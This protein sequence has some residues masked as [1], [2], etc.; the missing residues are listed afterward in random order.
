MCEMKKF[1]PNGYIIAL[2]K[3]TKTVLYHECTDAM[4]KENYKDLKSTC[5]LL[6]LIHTEGQ[7]NSSPLFEA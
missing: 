7:E 3:K 4:I 5:A 6:Q 2:A 1:I